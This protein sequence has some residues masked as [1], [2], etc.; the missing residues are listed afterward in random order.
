MTEVLSRMLNDPLTRAALCGGGEESLEGVVLNQENTQSTSEN[1]T[2]N[3]VEGHNE[4]ESGEAA[5]A[6]QSGS[7]ETGT[8]IY[9][10]CNTSTHPVHRKQVLPGDTEIRVQVSRKRVPVLPRANQVRMNPRWRTKLQL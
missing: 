4:A 8:Y 7:Q 10:F 2:E 1:A 5:A 3:T 6:V 9:L